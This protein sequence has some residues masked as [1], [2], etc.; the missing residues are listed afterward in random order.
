MHSLSWKYGAFSPK[1]E[2]WE[3]YHL[4]GYVEPV[5]PPRKGYPLNDYAEPVIPPIEHNIFMGS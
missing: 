5:I 3:R 4:N 2:T 1:V